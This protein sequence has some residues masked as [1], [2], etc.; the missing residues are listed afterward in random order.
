MRHQSKGRPIY[1]CRA[2]N[3]STPIQSPRQILQYRIKLQQSP[4]VTTVLSYVILPTDGWYTIK[5]V[6]WHTYD[7]VLALSLEQLIGPEPQMY[8]RMLRD[9]VP[10]RFALNKRSLAQIDTTLVNEVTGIEGELLEVF[11]RKPPLGTCARLFSDYV[12]HCYPSA[13]MTEPKFYTYLLHFNAGNLAAFFRSFGCDRRKYL[14]FNQFTWTC[15][16]VCRL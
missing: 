7:E 3:S 13:Y 5:Q 15:G 6:K 12:Q 9:K 8:A 1:Y 14:D 16:N 4:I 10:L 2:I 11:I